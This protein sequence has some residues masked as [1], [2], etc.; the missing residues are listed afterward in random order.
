M[1]SATRFEALFRDLGREDALLGLLFPTDGLLGAFNPSSRERFYSRM[2]AVLSEVVPAAF[3]QDDNSPPPRTRP[4][5][6][7]AFF[8][9]AGVMRVTGGDASVWLSGQARLGEVH[10][11]L[12]A[13]REVF[14]LSAER[15]AAEA[16]QVLAVVESVRQKERARASLVD[17]LPDVDAP[18][19]DWS[20]GR[21][22]EI[23]S[24]LLE[25]LVQHPS[26]WVQYLAALLFDT[27]QHGD[28]RREAC[29]RMLHVSSGDALYWAAALTI[30]LPI[31]SE[32]LIRRL[33]GRAVVGLHH[34]F[35]RLK[36][37]GCRISASHLAALEN[38][39]FNCG[40]KTAVSAARW[41][42]AT[43]SSADTWLL[44]SVQ[45]ASSYW[46]ENEKPYPKR[47]GAVPD[48]PR[49][50]LLRT[51]CMIA[52]PAFGE[53]VELAGDPRRDV[54]G[55]AI[56]G[57]VELAT[58]SPK[59]KLKLVEGILGKRFSAG[60]CETLLGSSV[61]YGAE[62]LSILCGLC[63]DPD[64]AFRS[65]AVRGVLD[66]PRMDRKKALAVVDSMRSDEDGIVRDTVH[67]FLERG[68]KERP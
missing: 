64:P 8:D 15:L 40:A 16:S 25:G 5:Y 67:R 12:R 62:E 46:V 43:A 7:A 52:M 59:D 58:S 2:M 60:Q 32:M 19:V 53:L 11:L 14:K 31:A 61:Q 24:G 48:S 1:G 33:E 68:A 3:L 42:E 51:R 55:A 27:R 54:A 20:R 17:V 30:D 26:Q 41:C 6:L 9:L 63:G 44:D 28:E 50:A 39:L 57:I 29:E 56:D 36:E 4:K 47:G 37:Q 23:D 22:V 65:V 45:S 35:D 49:E 18:E 38:G 10:I 66:H 21:S 13:F 34:L